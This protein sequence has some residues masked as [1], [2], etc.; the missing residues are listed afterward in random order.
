[1]TTH[2]CLINNVEQLVI[3]L[4]C[5]PTFVIIRIIYK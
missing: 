5:V 2:V 4:G 3:N 1:M